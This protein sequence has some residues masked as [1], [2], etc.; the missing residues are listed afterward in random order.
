METSGRKEMDF[1]SQECPQCGYMYM[2]FYEGNN[3][4]RFIC[5]DCGHEEVRQ[6]TKSGGLEKN[7]ET[8][9]KNSNIF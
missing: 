1:S 9:G 8:D 4:V 2:E 3:Y 5:P 7:G 6:K